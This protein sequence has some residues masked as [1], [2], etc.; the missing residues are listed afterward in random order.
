MP[1][2]SRCCPMV[3]HIPLVA[4]L[5]IALLVIPVYAEAETLDNADQIARITEDIKKDGLIDYQISMKIE[6]TG[7]V[8]TVHYVVENPVIDLILP[9]GKSLEKIFVENGFEIEKHERDGF[10]QIRAAKRY[11]DLVEF[12][13]ESVGFVSNMNV[14]TGSIGNMFSGQFQLEE[15]FDIEEDTLKNAIINGTKIVLCMHSE[16]PVGM[17]NADYAVDGTSTWIFKP[18]RI[19][20]ISFQID[21]VSSSKS[22]IS[23]KSLLVNIGILIG[24]LL[25]GVFAIILS[26]VIFINGYA[27][28]KRGIQAIKDYKESV[29]EE[30]DNFEFE[31]LSYLGDLYYADLDPIKGSEQ[32]GVRPVLVIQNDIGNKYSPTTIVVVITSKKKNKIPTH[33]ELPYT[34]LLPKNSIILAEQIR[35]IDKC[36]F[37]NKI[38]RLDEETMSKGDQTL[39]ISLALK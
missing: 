13:N 16:N 36:R 20:S 25:F 33:V 9:E 30:Y 7:E 29:N 37:K 39:H 34:G 10:R 1:Y 6:K 28:F 15:Y 17:S 2:E 5:L 27:W 19:N 31:D 38:G 32:G 3:K 12:S 35:V 18:G 4:L 22:L 24:A 21:A 14:S 11:K 23:G 26:S 8:D